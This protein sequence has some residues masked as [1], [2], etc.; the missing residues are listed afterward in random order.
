[1]PDGRV[2]GQHR[3]AERRRVQRQPPTG[4]DG[5]RPRRAAAHDRDAHHLAAVADRQMH[6]LA[7]LVAKVGHDRE[8]RD[9]ELA[10]LLGELTELEEPQAQVDQLAV[11]LEIALA[12]QGRDQP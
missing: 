1:M 8:R 4:A 6:V 12:H 3:L 10:G 7:G 11:A 5:R 2:V 9:P